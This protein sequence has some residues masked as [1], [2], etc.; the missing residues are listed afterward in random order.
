MIEFDF[1]A[2]RAFVRQMKE[3]TRLRLE[4]AIL[5]AL[6]SI[7]ALSFIEGWIS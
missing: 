3:E 5:G 7:T 1:P 6:M 4:A 2:G